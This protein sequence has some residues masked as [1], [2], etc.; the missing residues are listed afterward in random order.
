MLFP[1]CIASLFL[2][3]AEVAGMLGLSAV[4]PVLNGAVPFIVVFFA[5]L[6]SIIEK[7]K[8]K[9]LLATL[10]YGAFYSIFIVR[11]GGE[12]GLVFALVI[13][14]VAVALYK[15]ANIYFATAL[16]AVFALLIAFLSV[17][18]LEYAESFIMLSAGF[19]SRTSFIAPSLYGA[20]NMLCNLLDIHSFEELFL[21]SSYGSAQLLG[22]SIVTGAFDL[23]SAGGRG[24][25]L[26]DFITGK[27]L[28]LIGL[29][30]AGVGLFTNLKGDRKTA[31]MI[32]LICAL[33]SGNYTLFLLSLILICPMAL[34]S[35][36]MLFVIS[37]AV[38]SVLDLRTG[39]MFNGGIIELFS[40]I[41]KPFYLALVSV[42][43]FA[44]GYFT[45]NYN[46]LKF[47]FTDICEIY[48]P[49]S[50][51]GF[52][53]SLGGVRN[54]SAIKGNR[55][56]VKNIK[57]INELELED[58]E[59]KDNSLLFSDSKKLDELKGYLE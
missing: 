47:S 15:N 16:L 51:E 24:E 4:A 7:R 43:F 6:G 19:V 58:F 39:Y 45:L 54:I 29:F 25:Y 1:L 18:I 9:A 49:Q 30:G 41:N 52:V 2:V 28:A 59:V 13:T 11:N 5:T 31:V 27:Y 53:N 44:F 35:V 36:I 3:G 10:C 20:V 32:I 21:H 42:L 40:Y 23:F 50:L 55:V 46:K 37:F 8:I 56:N 22:D 26:A 34:V 38:S 57:L 17:Y 33:I 14:L 48:I 12:A